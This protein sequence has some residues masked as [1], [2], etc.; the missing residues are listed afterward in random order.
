MKRRTAHER[1]GEWIGL[2][3][4]ILIVVALFTGCATPLPHEHAAF[5]SPSPTMLRAQASQHNSSSVRRAK[6][7]HIEKNPRCAFC[8]IKSN[9]VNGH[10][11][12]VHHLV[13]ISFR[14]DLGATPDNL[15]TACRFCHFSYCH[16][17]NW[18]CYNPY[19]LHMSLEMRNIGEAWQE[20]AMN[21][22]QRKHSD[23]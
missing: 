10:R 11:N 21:E 1:R 15:L 6:R 2:S 3:G 23:E 16:L 19:A 8:G 18:S 22:F 7:E 17:S 12:D 5:D 9:I 4:L 20:R 14:P 13:P